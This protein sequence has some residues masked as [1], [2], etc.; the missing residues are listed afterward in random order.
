MTGV[1]AIE[2]IFQVSHRRKE[3]LFIPLIIPRFP[4][5]ETYKKI[6]NHLLSL[7]IRAIET[8][9]TISPRFSA[10]TGF[11]VRTIAINYTRINPQ[12]I[13]LN[14]QPFRPRLC[15]IFG[16]VAR[17]YREKII[18]NLSTLFDGLIF[19][20]SWFCSADKIK[21]TNKYGVAFIPVI[22]VKYS[23]IQI[24]YALRGGSGFVYLM[25]STSTGGRFAAYHDI[26]KTIITIKK[27]TS[28]PICC[29]FGIKNPLHIRTARRAGADGIIVGTSLLQPLQ[30]GIHYW[31]RK[32]YKMKDACTSIR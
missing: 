20:N 22:S 1:R 12:R 24:R 13:A 14:L 5:T 4:D 21:L 18:Y 6:S 27:Q 31:K 2:K 28:L 11:V 30:H 9:W 7:K 32:V 19:D 16:K 29:A 17:Q 10:E 8:I 23:P 26:K 3:V 25:C 15:V